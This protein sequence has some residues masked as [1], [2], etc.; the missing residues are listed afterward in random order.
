MMI[1]GHLLR[2]VSIG[3]LAFSGSRKCRMEQPRVNVQLLASWG[4][5]AQVSKYREDELKN[6]TSRDCFLLVII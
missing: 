2:E 6:C 5:R 4:R 3:G 1:Y